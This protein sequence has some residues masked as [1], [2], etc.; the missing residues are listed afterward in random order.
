MDSTRVLDFD[1]EEGVVR[2]PVTDASNLQ[3]RVVD[4]AEPARENSEHD[5]SEP[6]VALPSGAAA[7]SEVARAQDALDVYLRQIG[8]GDLLS[9]EDEL[10]LAKRIAAAQTR[11]LG[12]LC[13]VPLAIDMI[14]GWVEGVREGRLRSTYL[15]DSLR[16]PEDPDAPE[17]VVPD[18]DTD[19]AAEPA[20]LEEIG[21]ELELIGLVGSEIAGLAGK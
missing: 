15:L 7:A 5:G 14:A 17:T 3:P 19:L 13:R 10:A 4:G 1:L 8:H 11:L 20:E 12:A 9:R 2:P 6:A 16:G 21:P 18:L